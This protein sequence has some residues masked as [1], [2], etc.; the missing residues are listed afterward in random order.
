MPDEKIKYGRN[1]K[2]LFMK[3]ISNA[4]KMVKDDV[5]TV[6]MNIDVNSNASSKV[7]PYI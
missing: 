2:V 6:L 3:A 1:W 7:S 5:N 4:V